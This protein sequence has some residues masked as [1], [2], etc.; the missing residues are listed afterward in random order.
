MP[1]VSRELLRLSLDALKRSYSPLAVISL[2]CMLH[3]GIPTCRTPAEAQE[4]G[5]EFGSTDEREWLDQFFRVPGGPPDKPYFMPATGEW[6]QERYPD[7]SLQRRR[8]D[9]EDS[10]FYHP[11]RELWALREDAAQIAARRCIPAGQP[12]IP[13]V[14]LMA[15]MWR[16][17]E[18]E[19]LEA[20]LD[21]FM[22]EINLNREN[23]VGTLYSAE[24]PAAFQ[25]AGLAPDPLTAEDIADLTGAVPPPPVAPALEDMVNRLE[26]ALARNHFRAPPGL[27]ERVLGGWLVQDIVVL[28]GP[29][30]SGKTSLARLLA[31]GLGQLLGEDRFF[32]SFLEVT[33][34]YDLAQFLGYENLAGEYTKGDFAEE[35]L[36]VGQPT[37]PRLVVLDEWNLAQIDSYFAPILSAVESRMPLH[38]PGRVDLQGMEEPDRAEL[39]RA[40]PD[41]TEGRWRLPEDTFFIATCNSWQEEPETR[42]PISGPVKRRCRIIPMPNVLEG[43]VRQ[44][45]REGLVAF[46]D[47]F[48]EQE[49][50]AVQQRRQAGRGSIL[51]RHRAAR[52]EQIQTTADLPENVRDAL[53]RIAQ[54]LLGNAHTKSSFT[55]GILKDLLMSCAYARSGSEY[56][57]LGQEIADK[58]LH[59][60]QGDPQILRVLSDQTRDFPNADEIS[61]LIRR[62][63]GL[64]TDRRIRPL[65]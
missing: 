64:G 41:V 18:I 31:E 63:G 61:D 56:M 54:I 44:D 22:R 28:V 40:Q 58:V 62:M 55:P 52:L 38:L 2:P 29:T 23:F 33:P 53:L 27:V 15:W 34:N 3:H 10:V 32:T 25:D 6:V 5:I 20:G 12:P 30:G 36:F 37:D 35:V 9:F 47:L 50:M 46:C 4:R 21:A 49:R 42:L 48:L 19:S 8:K 43:A 14:A 1:Y 45:G 39:T 59:Q 24:I 60:L 65:V 7:R 57:A 13:L 17:R 11:T 51:D 16:E 26:E